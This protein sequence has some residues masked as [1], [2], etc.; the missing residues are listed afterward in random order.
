M[1]KFCLNILLVT[2]TSGGGTGRHIMDLSRKLL[3]QGHSVT[4]IYA[5]NRAEVEFLREVDELLHE[6]RFKPIECKMSREPSLTD[7]AAYLELYRLIKEMGPFD[8]LHAHSSKAGALVRAMPKKFGPKIY[9]PHALKVMDPNCGGLSKK[10]FGAVEAYLGKNRSDAVIAVSP[11]EM[12]CCISLGIPKALIKLVVNGV[13]PGCSS[14]ISATRSDVG[15]PED[16]HIFGYVGRF[17]PQKAPE[18]LINAFIE[19]NNPKTGLLVIGDGPDREILVERIKNAGVSDRVCFVGASNAAKFYPIM[20]TFVMPSRY[21]S[22]P[23]VL[24]EASEF[25]LPIIATDVSGSDLVVADQ[26]NGYVIPNCDIVEHLKSA[27]SRIIISENWSRI[28]RNAEER[29][30]RFSVERMAGETMSIYRSVM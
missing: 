25:G 27:M 12:E 9:T 7:I 11:A 8:V 17:A 15:F 6:A 4:M 3:E 29:T 23:Y 2:E 16:I 10:F 5:P 30:G 14:D 20:D 22:M 26:E 21:E 24:L 13:Y 18:R 28:K 1:Q 19:L